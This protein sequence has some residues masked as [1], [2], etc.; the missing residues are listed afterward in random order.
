MAEQVGPAL[1]PEL[2]NEEE[3]KASSSTP[4]LFWDD[5]P[6]NFEEHP[7]YVAMHAAMEEMTPFERAEDLKNVGNENLRKGR[8]AAQTRMK[9]RFYREAVDSYTKAID[10]VKKDPDTSSSCNFVG[11]CFNNRAQVNLMLTNY[12]SALEDAEEA[13]KIDKSNRKAYFR[14]VKA[15]LELKEIDVA[16]SLGRRGLPFA[17][18]DKDYADLMAQV[19]RAEKEVKAEADKETED[20]QQSLSTAIQ[21]S[22]LLKQREVKICFPSFPDIQNKPYLDAEGIMHWPVIMVYPESGQVEFIE[23]FPEESPFSP[24]LDLMFNEDVS[25][26]PW[27]VQNEY[28]KSKITL[29]YNTSYS[30]VMPQ[31][32]LLKW[33]DGNH[34][35]EQDR[36]WKKESWRKIDPKTTMKKMLSE[37]DCVIPGLPSVYALA[38]NSF[39]QKF[40]AGDW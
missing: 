11:I 13:I 26:F 15:A 33:L 2:K 30:K 28:T 22:L 25:S 38:D 6:E 36:T 24:F 40:L 35:G 17:K 18:K 34:V 32:T 1:P 9:R 10:T 23:D 29:Y 8:K 14:A 3:G 31:D 39:H 5:A 7:D 21:F 4:S 20:A 27:D 37:K 16:L 19:E 12:R